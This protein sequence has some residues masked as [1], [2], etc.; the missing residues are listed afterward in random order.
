MRAYVPARSPTGDS[1]ALKRGC[2]VGRV[3]SRH[4]ETAPEAVRGTRCLPAHELFDEERGEEPLDARADEA[5]RPED[6]SARIGLEQQA[7]YDQLVR[8]AE[9]G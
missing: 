1:G 5:N 3:A 9:H 2:A 4:P 7:A 8:D 6:D